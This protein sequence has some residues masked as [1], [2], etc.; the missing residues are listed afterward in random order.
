MRLLDSIARRIARVSVIPSIIFLVSLGIITAATP[1]SAQVGHTLSGVGPVDQAMSGAATANPQDVLGAIHWNPATLT[2]FDT[3]QL[4][5]GIQLLFPS[6]NLSSS[7]SAGAFGPFGPPVAL[8]GTTEGKAG[9]FP[10]PALG[11]IRGIGDSNWT[12]GVAALVAGGFGTD[13]ALSTSFADNPINLP[14]PPNGLG[15]G[16]INSTFAMMQLVPTFA[17]RVNDNI[18]VGIAPT[19]NYA[20]LEVAPFPAAAPDD[21]NGDGFPSYADAPSTGAV[22]FGVQAG[23]HVTMDSGISLGASIKSPQNFSEFEFDGKNESGAA[24]SMV[25]DLDY[26]MIISAGVGYSGE[27]IEIAADVRY[28]DYENTNGFSDSGFD[29]TG[30]VAG[31]GWKSITVVAVGLQ[32]RVTEKMPIRLGYSFNENPIEDDLTFFNTPANA[33]IQSRISGGLSYDATEK[34]T[35]S[36]GFQYGLENSIEGNWKHPQF[37]TIQ[38]ATVK[39]TLSTL[40]LM[41]GIQMS[42]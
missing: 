27:K 30:A 7:V 28:I 6:S 31:F 2:S 33:I 38:G 41:F 40:F 25:F 21:A 26:P 20:L 24:K 11:Y 14:Q 4:S 9:P 10:M 17:Y 22:G 29:N 42:L 35:A 39:S 16:A 23:I 15:F 1:V 34:L 12:F 8:S 5:I 37:G 36:L 32:Y 3:S 13:Y 19:I 18:S